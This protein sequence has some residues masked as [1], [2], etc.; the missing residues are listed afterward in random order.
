MKKKSQ[1]SASTADSD[2]GTN[3][4]L[5]AKGYVMEKP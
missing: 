2:F 3:E 5:S 4:T 1:Q